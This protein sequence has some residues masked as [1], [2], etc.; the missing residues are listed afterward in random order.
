MCVHVQE[1][2]SKF[3]HNQFKFEK[4]Q[5][6]FKV[7]LQSN[8]VEEISKNFQSPVQV[9]WVWKKFQKIFKVPLKQDL[10]EKI[11]KF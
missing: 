5:K 9:N 4:F 6:S 2:N 8:Q 11:S 10:S 3:K 7:Q 1:K